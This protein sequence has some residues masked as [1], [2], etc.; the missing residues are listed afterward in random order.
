MVQP[1]LPSAAVWL[2]L[3]QVF[4]GI[5]LVAGSIVIGYMVYFV[6][7]YREGKV[8]QGSNTNGPRSPQ[9]SRREAILFASIS[10]VILFSLA[11]VTT[12]DT[13]NIMTPPTTSQS[14]TIDVTAFQWAFK[15][16][17]PNN[18]SIV[19]DCIVPS[20]EPIIFNVT[21]SDVMHDFG[22]PAFRLKIDAIPGRYNTI[23]IE[24]PTVA[25]VNGTQYEIKCYELCGVGHT[26][27]TANLTVMDPASFNQWYTS[28]SQQQYTVPNVM[29]DLYAGELSNT[30]Y[31]F[32]NSST[33]ITS[34]GPSFTVQVNDTVMVTFHNVGNMPHSFAVVD[35]LGSNYNILFNSSIGSGSSPIPSSGTA[36]VT[37]VASQAGTYYYICTVPGHEALGMWGNFTVS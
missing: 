28:H 11:V 24:V 23:W 1:I 36:S 16:T 20:G 5:G 9:K 33:T 26:Y 30:Q 32:G 15:F 14:L 8:P 17:Y 12:R 27:M 18:V 37:F 22:L 34:P 3:F 7:K 4:L 35:S 29:I 31:G 6:Y 25:G 21:S 2:N 19:G 10:V 13:M